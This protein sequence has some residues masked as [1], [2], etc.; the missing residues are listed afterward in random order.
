MSLRSNLS[1][2]TQPRAVYNEKV[3]IWESLG[4]LIHYSAFK[5]VLFYLLSLLDCFV[6]L[7]EPWG[8]FSKYF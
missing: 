8:S 5:I 7:G 3:V 2:K 4:A 1:S 6:F